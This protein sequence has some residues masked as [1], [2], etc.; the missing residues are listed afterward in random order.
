MKSEDKDRLKKLLIEAFCQYKEY[1]NLIADGNKAQLERLKA[2]SH[3]KGFD[4]IEIEYALDSIR[5]KTEELQVA[6]SCYN[7]EVM[8]DKAADIANFAHMVILKCDKLT[9]IAKRAY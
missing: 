3:K 5:K 7:S 6:L 2:N 9:A 4:D 1:K 8:R